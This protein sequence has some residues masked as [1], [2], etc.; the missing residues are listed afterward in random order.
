MY[1]VHFNTMGNDDSKKA[2]QSEHVV[3]Y[4]NPALAEQSPRNFTKS[5]VINVFKLPNVDVWEC[6]KLPI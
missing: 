4:S 6:I 2:S 3:S 1:S 5:P